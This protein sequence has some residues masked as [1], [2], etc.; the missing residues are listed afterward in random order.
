MRHRSGYLPG[1]RVEWG[2]AVGLGWTGTL[3]E[4]T[5]DPDTGE[6]EWCGD[7]EEPAALWRIRFDD[8]RIKER[9]CERMIVQKIGWQPMRTGRSRR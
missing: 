5:S 7:H 4:R 2:E 1:D 9:C 3:L 8:G 6:L